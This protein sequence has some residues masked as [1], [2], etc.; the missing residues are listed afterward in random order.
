MELQ[1]WLYYLLA[2]FVLTAVPGPS[3]LLCM[4]KAV[5]S[6]FSASFYAALGS[7]TAIYII[8]TLSFTGLGV[9]VSQSEWA[10]N[11]IKWLGVL[12]LFYLGIK[13]ITSPQKNYRA[14]SSTTT[15]QLKSNT[16]KLGNYIDGFVVGA[17]N[18][19]AIVFFTALFP[20]F[21][22]PNES[23]LTQYLVLAL[24][25]VILEFAWLM[26]YALLGYRSS[27]WLMQDG[28]AQLFNRITGGTFIGLGVWLSSSSRTNV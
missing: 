13:A 12:Y 4:T 21:I 25:F 28:R 16:R 8:L 2:I 11:L 15:S 24:T 22:N 9:V 5:S 7:L 18:P 23:L 19:K 3:V 26:A 20:Q 6:G 10:F 1:N 17:S 27:L 14:I